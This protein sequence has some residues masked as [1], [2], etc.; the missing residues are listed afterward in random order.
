[1]A[2]YNGNNGSTGSSLETR[3]L[4]LESDKDSLRLQVTELCFPLVYLGEKFHTGYTS[5]YLGTQFHTWVQNFIPGYKISYL[6][7]CL[8]KECNEISF[9]SAIVSYPGVKLP[10]QV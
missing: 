6:V 1:V 3:M 8:F 9:W 5:S 7:A 4:Q 10:T 2:A